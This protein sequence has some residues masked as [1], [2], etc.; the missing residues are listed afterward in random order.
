MNIF[1]GYRSLGVKALFTA[2][3][4]SWQFVTQTFIPVTTVQWVHARAESWVEE[5]RQALRNEKER[6]LRAEHG[7]GDLVA[8]LRLLLSLLDG[9]GAANKK[10]IDL[11]SQELRDRLERIEEIWQWGDRM[12]RSPRVVRWLQPFTVRRMTENIMI[13]A[14]EAVAA[15]A[16]IEIRQ[17]LASSI[18]PALQD[19]ASEL[20]SCAASLVER[21]R[22]VGN[23]CGQ[24]SRRLLTASGLAKAPVGIELI[25]GDFLRAFYDDA[26]REAGTVEEIVPRL[27]ESFLARHGALESFLEKPFDTLREALLETCEPVFLDSLGRLDVE[28][29]LKQAADTPERLREYVLQAIKE[30][31]GRIRAP[32]AVA[33]ESLRIKLLAVAEPSRFEWLLRPTN[34]LDREPGEWNLVSNGGDK[35]TIYFFQFRAGLALG[36]LISGT[37]TS[38]EPRDIRAAAQQ[39]PDPVSA[40][41]PSPRPSPLEVDIA[42]VKAA[43]VGAL[44][45]VEGEGI[46]L[47]VRGD[48]KFLGT[49]WHEVKERARRSYADLVGMHSAFAERVFTAPDATTLDTQ[50]LG[51]LEVDPAAVR[52]VLA[53]A[54]EFR[55]YARRREN[56]E[57]Y[58]QEITVS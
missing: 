48:R 42:L 30:S 15:L 20:L 41:L 57:G 25:D 16:Q 29:V 54:A 31:A 43:S 24:E 35:D 46:Y 5:I 19:T 23:G 58:I 45:S 27:M 51:S 37:Q 13:D 49:G 2:R 47:V 28:I 9:F 53:E 34:E 21:I 52:V 50:R 18:Y 6:I 11:L 8:I 44:E 40:R 55:R 7:P 10:K 39:G 3:S 1:P 14:E 36:S 38:I 12:K 17:A 4:Y 22:A 33:D 26:I 56:Q 32:D